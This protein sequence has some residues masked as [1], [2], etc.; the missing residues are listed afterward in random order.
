MTIPSSPGSRPG[1]VYGLMSCALEPVH[2]HRADEHG[3]AERD[4]GDGRRA[5][6]WPR[7]LAPARASGRAGS[8]SPSSESAMTAGDRDQGFGMPTVSGETLAL[9]PSNSSQALAWIA[10]NTAFCAASPTTARTARRGCP[11]T[12][13]APRSCRCSRPR[14][15][16]ASSRLRRERPSAGRCRSSWPARVKPGT[17]AASG[18]IVPYPS[19]SSGLS[20]TRR[21]RTQPLAADHVGLL[22]GELRRDLGLAG[23]RGDDRGVAAVVGDVA[24]LDAGRLARSAPSRCGRPR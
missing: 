22:D 19:S 12:S 3:D 7:A 4:P 20:L 1:T 6:R 23:D 2:A 21:E 13:S 5:A 14:P 9:P 10:G 15:S 11:R 16:R 24:V 8:T 17:T 18:G